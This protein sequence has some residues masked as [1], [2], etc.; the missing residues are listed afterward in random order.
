MALWEEAMPFLVAA[1]RAYG[2]GVLAGAPDVD[3]AAGVGRGLLRTCLVRRLR[4]AR[5]LSR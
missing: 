3:T 1:A 5:C 2:T 4:T